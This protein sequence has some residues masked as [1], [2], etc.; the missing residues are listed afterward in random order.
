[1][2]SDRSAEAVGYA[3]TRSVV[4]GIVLIVVADGIFAVV[5]TALGI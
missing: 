4:T 1:M 5:T 3:A 2:H